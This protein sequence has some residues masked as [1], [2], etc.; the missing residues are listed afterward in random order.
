VLGL[1]A[2]G[3]LA[4]A[5]TFFVASGAGADLGRIAEVNHWTG[6]ALRIAFVFALVGFI[7][8]AWEFSKGWAPKQRLVF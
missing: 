3:L 4:S 7:K 2:V 5:T 1:F 6:I 8:H